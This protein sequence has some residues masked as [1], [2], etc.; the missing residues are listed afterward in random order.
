MWLNKQKKYKKIAF[1][2]RDG[3]I[4]KKAEEHH[5][6]D[7]VENFEFNQGIFDVLTYLKKE[8]Y[9]FI[10]VT[11]QRGIARGVYS[12]EMLDTIH[13]YMMKGLQEKGFSVLD[14]LFCPHE[15]NVCDCRKPKPGLLK[16]AS[17]RHPIIFA[18]SLLISD[19]YE[20]IV[21]GK[22]FGV[23]ATYFVRSDK[24]EDF[25]LMIDKSS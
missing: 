3:V 19:S 1:L 2:D 24:P 18:N 5:Y 16:E 11:N 9:E 14:I 23:G 25:L 22:E 13:R 8:G 4:N 15:N 21:M 17:M 12:L 10:V 7:T 20:D 6:I